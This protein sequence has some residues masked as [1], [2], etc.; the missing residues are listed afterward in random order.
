MAGLAHAKRLNVSGSSILERVHTAFSKGCLGEDRLGIC[1]ERPGGSD[2][3][4]WASKLVSS[5]PG[6]RAI[7]V[8]LKFWRQNCGHTPDKVLT[9]HNNYQ[10]LWKMHQDGVFRRLIVP[11]FFYSFIE[12]D[13]NLISLPVCRRAAMSSRHD[14]GEVRN[15]LVVVSDLTEGKKYAILDNVNENNIP[16]S[17]AREIQEDLRFLEKQ[18]P[19][20]VMGTGSF[21]L[22]SS[23]LIVKSDPPRVACGDIDKLALI[24]YPGSPPGV[25][26]GC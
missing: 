3:I 24:F 11:R 23:L 2:T 25:S 4:V 9:I 12:I 5:I 20:G 6:T 8:V 1:S 18:M 10:T 13:E 22:T 21:F 15:Q 17:F 7:P 14:I 26:S 16:T 19:Y